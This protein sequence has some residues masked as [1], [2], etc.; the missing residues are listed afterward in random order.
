MSTLRTR[1]I[2]L[3]FSNR[4]L[5][6]HLLPL[7]TQGKT[8]SV[9][10]KVLGFVSDQDPDDDD[11]EWAGDMDAQVSL[12]GREV[13]QLLGK[14]QRVLQSALEKLTDK[15]ASN[16]LVSGR[17]PITRSVLRS[18]KSEAQRYAK[19]YARDEFGLGANVDVVDFTDDHSYW[20]V[21]IDPKNQKIDFNIEIQVSGEWVGRK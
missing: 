16:A 4:S 12:Q 17:N 19:S 14:Q 21:K 8:A 6:P 7:L 5:R 18:L 15:A 3:A 1:V 10:V 13:A 2:K 20:T 11:D 9:K